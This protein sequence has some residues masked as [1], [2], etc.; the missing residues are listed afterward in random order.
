MPKSDR[1]EIQ[2]DDEREDARQL[3]LEGNDPPAEIEGYSIVRRLGTGAYGTVWLAR[4]EHT[5][6]MV[7]IKYYPHRRGLNWSLLNREVEKLATLYA[8]RNIVRLLDVGWNAEPPYYVMEFVENGSLGAYLASGPV[9]VEEAVRISQEVCGALIEAHGAGVLHCDLKPDNVLLDAQFQIRLCDFGQSRMS[10]EQSP[11]LGTLYYMAP[12]QADLEAIPD[13]RWDVY[14]VGALNYHMLTGQPPYRATDIQQKLEHAESLQDRLRIYKEHIQEAPPPDL[15]R[16]VK[17]VDRHLA[18]I[19]DLCLA[20]EP[21]DRLPNAQAIRTQLN[22]RERQRSRRPLLLLGVLGPLLLIGAML[23]IFVG[24]LN[25]IIAETEQEQIADEQNKNQMLA[26]THAN[27]LQG[28]LENRL[29][30]LEVI[31]AQDDVIASLTDLMNRPAEEAAEEMKRHQGM[32][33]AD[34]PD[35][36]RRLDTVHQAEDEWNVAHGRNTDTSWFLTDANGTQLWRRPFPKEDKMT[37]GHLYAWRDYFHGQGVEFDHDNPPDNLKPIQSPYVS[38]AFRSE[39]TNRYMVA[40]SVPVRS[41]DGEVIGLFA[42]TLHLG[43]LQ[44]RLGQDIR[45]NSSAV[46][47]LADHRQSMLLDHP[48]LTDEFCDQLSKDQ[49]RAMFQQLKLSSDDQAAIAK[50]MQAGGQRRTVDIQSTTYVDPISRLHFPFAKNYSGEYIASM[51]TIR[52]DRMPWLVIVQQ[53]RAAA[54]TTVR[55]MKRRATRQAW[56]AVLMSLAAMLLVWLFVWQALA[57]AKDPKPRR[58]AARVHA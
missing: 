31:V 11:A 53:D 30:R 38:V 12:E 46:I 44:R 32:P 50:A 36:M 1:T 16:S 10:H 40:L 43:E 55:S 5:G 34:R 22:N 28:E 2:N 9:D 41:K 17:G 8:S 26:R 21:K 7:A 19:I 47:A 25:R 37:I 51:S 23:P 24:E 49:S 39:A 33:L 56:F 27:A 4:E 54:L 3:S 14:A 20:V 58:T 48:S 29:R 6:R 42:R 52:N 18:S 15:H 45:G 57:R 13:A 35:W